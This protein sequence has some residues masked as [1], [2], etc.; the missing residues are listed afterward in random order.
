MNIKLNSNKA[1]SVKL[2][3]IYMISALLFLSS[4]ELHIHTHEAAASADH[5]SAVSITSLLNDFSSKFAAQESAS[6]IEVSPDGMLHAHQNA[7]NML[8]IFLLL[9]LIVTIFIPVSISRIRKLHCRIER[10][11]YGTPSLR[12]PPHNI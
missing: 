1:L 8:A 2:L 3:V 5:G 11:F 4:I 12:A 10:P 9:V 6:E 7:P